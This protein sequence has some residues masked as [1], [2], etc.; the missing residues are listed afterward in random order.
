[1]KRFLLTPEAFSDLE[2]ISDYIDSDSHEAA[3]RVRLSLLNA[4]R[5]LGANPGM[6]HLREELCAE[7][8]RF[9]PVY[10]YLIIYRAEVKPIQVLR[11]IHG[12][13]DIR[14]LLAKT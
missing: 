12:A 10:S 1:M 5:K 2:E 7:P 14:A 8:V 9:W 3:R 6:G 13:R 11:I 4:M